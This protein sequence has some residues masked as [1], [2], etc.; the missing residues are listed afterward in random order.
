MT[1]RYYTRSRAVASRVVDGE[2]VLVKMPEAQ[3]YCL[4]AAAS[5]MWV[6]ADGRTSEGEL[7]GGGEA[8]AARRFLDEMVTS[9]L[10]QSSASA[11]EAVESYPQDVAWPSSP[12]DDAP[13]AIVASERVD[14]TAGCIPPEVSGV[15]YDPEA[16]PPPFSV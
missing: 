9:G 3:L 2:A 4:N 14:A 7:V 10:M 13:P 5:R 6:A 8:A 1:D 15:C 11:R 12:D 16:P